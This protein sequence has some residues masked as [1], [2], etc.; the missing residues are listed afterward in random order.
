[1]IIISSL[2]FFSKT[3]IIVRYQLI[4]DYHDPILDK[5]IHVGRKGHKKDQFDAPL[6]PTRD[7]RNETAGSLVFETNTKPNKANNR[8]E[9]PN[10]NEESF[11][12][13][14]RGVVGSSDQ[15]S[16]QQTNNLTIVVVVSA[17]LVAFFVYHKYFR[18][19]QQ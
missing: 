18:R 10:G 17:S 19:R 14:S 7:M 8:L 6:R 13:D 15:G 16:A 4:V 11:V 5:K 1:M 2:F 12:D 9:K 3:K